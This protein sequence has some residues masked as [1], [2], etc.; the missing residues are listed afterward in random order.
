MLPG[1]TPGGTGC[2]SCSTLC[3]ALPIPSA[4]LAERRCPR[5]PR[6]RYNSSPALITS[7]NR[8]VPAVER[9]TRDATDPDGDAGPCVAGCLGARVAPCLRCPPRTGAVNGDSRG[10][11]ERLGGRQHLSPGRSST[12]RDCSGA[13]PW[14]RAGAGTRTTH[15]PPPPVNEILHPAAWVK[16]LPSRNT[17]ESETVSKD[18]GWFLPDELAE[19][20]QTNN[21]GLLKS[22]ERRLGPFCSFRFIALQARVRPDTAGDA[23]LE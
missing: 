2:L 11:L 13:R 9:M 23:G 12:G 22:V 20:V 10:P 1:R 17:K 19:F 21:Q 4:R 5:C 15:P 16:L 14:G 7:G 3:A 18:D 8:P 6:C